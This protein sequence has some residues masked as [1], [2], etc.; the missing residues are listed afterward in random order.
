MSWLPIVVLAAIT[1]V[2]AAFL[3]RVGRGGWTI[4]G[5]TLLF[6]LAGYA[7]QGSPGQPAA[8]GE[9]MQEEPID[10]E[11]LVEARREFFDT[12]QFPSR[13]IVTG[14]SYLRRGDFERASGFY[15]NAVEENPQDTEAWLG[16][17]IAL[18]EHADGQLTPAALH[19]FEKAQ[20]LEEEN[21][22]PRYFL[23][24]AWLRA[25]EAERTFE[26]WREALLAAP[27]DA[28]WRESLALRLMRLESMMRPAD[29]AE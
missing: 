8:P 28:P 4:L 20:A 13:W 19:A 24:F 18:V 14:D 3:L 2:V 26:L 6:G 22:G 12:S 21:G 15:R 5:A 27:E 7:L 16:L 29:A 9:A 17:G 23:G 1:F 11:L 10:G 25:G